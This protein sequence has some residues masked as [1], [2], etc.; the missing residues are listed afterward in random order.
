MRPM[1]SS[2]EIRLLP[3]YVH[4]AHP[5]SERIPMSRDAGFAVYSQLTL[6]TSGTGVFIDSNKTKYNIKPGYIFYFTP[7]AA[8]SYYSTCE[9]W[10]VKFILFGGIN[11]EHIMNYFSFAKSGVI[12]PPG[13][14][15]FAN[16]DALFDE[17]CELSSERIADHI[18]ISERLYE[19]IAQLGEYI[20]LGRN[21]TFDKK[22]KTIAPCVSFMQSDFNRDI[23]MEDVSAI[24]GISPNYMNALFKDVYNTTPR[25]FLIG[26]RIDYAR[27]VLEHDSTILLDDLALRSGFNSS[28]YFCRIFKKYTG[29]TPNDYREYHSLVRP[30]KT[31]F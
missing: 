13:D 29:M 9:D 31:V 2:R 4:H 3:L 12:C 18:K 1:L 27:K 11:A 20:Q 25:T 10:Q 8:H 22:K 14:E 30:A 16:L 5:H 28:S 6:C 7:A 26:I 15:A 24:A 21:N 17:I 23:S 19:L